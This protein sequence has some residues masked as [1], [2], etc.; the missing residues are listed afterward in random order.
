MFKSALDPFAVK[1]IIGVK[2]GWSLRFDGNNVS[3]LIF[4]F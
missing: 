1:N 2:I 3:E 4:S